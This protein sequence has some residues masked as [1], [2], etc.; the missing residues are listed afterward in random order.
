MLE[1]G[2][3]RATLFEGVN[4]RDRRRSLVWSRGAQGVNARPQGSKGYK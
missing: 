1:V 3:A 4:Q 2:E